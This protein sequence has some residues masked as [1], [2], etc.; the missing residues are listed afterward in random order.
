[1]AIL[2]RRKLRVEDDEIGPQGLQQLM[3]LFDLPIAKQETLR[4]PLH[5]GFGL[6]YFH[7]EAFGQLSCFF[8]PIRIDDLPDPPNAYNYGRSCNA[9]AAHDR[10]ARYC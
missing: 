9:F 1:M 2:Q 3:Q 4:G 6:E 8:R 10:G 7:A 5:V